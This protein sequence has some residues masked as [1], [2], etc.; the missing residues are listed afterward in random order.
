MSSRTGRTVKETLHQEKKEEEEEQK[1]EDKIW[2][3]KRRRSQS[4]NLTT[5]IE[6]EARLPEFIPCFCV[7]LCELS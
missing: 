6:S 7:Y 2:Q 1:E 5:E 3:P 4:Q